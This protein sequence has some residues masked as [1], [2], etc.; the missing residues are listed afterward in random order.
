MGTPART[1]RELYSSIFYKFYTSFGA[2]VDLVADSKGGTPGTSFGKEGVCCRRIVPFSSG[3]L[4]V[5]RSDGTNVTITAV[6]SGQVLD[7]QAQKIIASGTTVT[8]GLVHW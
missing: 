6:T 1:N 7:I 3:N 4:V 5:Q 8:A 2:D